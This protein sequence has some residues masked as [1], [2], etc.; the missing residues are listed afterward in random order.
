MSVIGDSNLIAED[1]FT[2]INITAMAPTL[3]TD[4]P[5]DSGIGFQKGR[6]QP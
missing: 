5:D 3:R 6:V 1:V 4:M 2:G